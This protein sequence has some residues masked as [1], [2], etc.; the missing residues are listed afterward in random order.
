M[1]VDLIQTWKLLDDENLPKF[2]EQVLWTRGDDPYE[3]LLVS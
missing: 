3:C 2:D 1:G